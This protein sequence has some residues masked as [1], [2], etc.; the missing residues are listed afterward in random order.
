MYRGRGGRFSDGDQH[1]LVIKKVVPVGRLFRRNLVSDELAAALQPFQNSDGV[2]EMTLPLIS[3]A[4]G[5][6]ETGVDL[7]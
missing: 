1:F 2:V 7:A 6:S 3:G 5:A 4:C